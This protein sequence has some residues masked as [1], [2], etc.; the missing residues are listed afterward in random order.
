MENFELVK[1]ILK[2]V[3]SFESITYNKLEI[4]GYNI[5]KVAY[6]ASLLR[7]AGYI[8]YYDITCYSVRVGALTMKGIC[9]ICGEPVEY[10]RGSQDRMAATIDHIV[11]LSKGGKH[12]YDNC[13]LAHRICNSLKRD[14]INYKYAQ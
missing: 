10:N 14:T 3:E 1:D 13:Q 7:N 6:Y 12:Q 9:Q 5:D 11:P 2:K 4:E 8:D